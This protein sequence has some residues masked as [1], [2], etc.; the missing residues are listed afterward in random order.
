MGAVAG[1]SATLIAIMAALAAA[2]TFAISAVLQQRAAADTPERLALSPRLLVELARHP[3]WLAGT[4]VSSVGFLLHILALAFG[5]LTLVQPLIVTQLVFAVLLAAP[6]G[7]RRLGVR[8]WSGALAVV[9]GIV[10][11]LAVARPHDGNSDPPMVVWLT[12]SFSL[13]LAASS[14]LL[15]MRA[16]LGPRRAT[17]LGAAGGILFGLQ[18][19]LMETVTFRMGPELVGTL[20][21][22]HLWAVIVVSA[23]A[24]V[25]S[26]SAFQAGSVAFSLPVMNVLELLMAVLIGAVAFGEPLSEAPA[27]ITLEILAGIAVIAGVFSLNRSPV[28]LELHQAVPAR[29]EPGR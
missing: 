20:T 4:V 1:P 11:F 6:S 25:C 21:S 23:V 13:L 10:V 29:A 17:W 14:V 2:V 24:A 15:G 12:I 22:W 5:P 16:P 18:A 3:V 19:A 28:F 27:A 26:Q 8:E 9:G 7:H